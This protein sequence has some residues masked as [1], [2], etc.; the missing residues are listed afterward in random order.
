MMVYLCM[1]YY[2]TRPP[3]NECLVEFSIL[4]TNVLSTALSLA[5]L[6]ANCCC[7]RS[8]LDSAKLASISGHLLSFE[9]WQHMEYFPSHRRVP[10]GLLDDVMGILA[11]GHIGILNH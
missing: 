2:T 3:W 8:R 6:A 5:R 4:V 11:H 10:T 9:F 7:N 1:W